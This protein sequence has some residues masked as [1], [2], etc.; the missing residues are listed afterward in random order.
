MKTT[1][2]ILIISLFGGLIKQ[3]KPT[4]SADNSQ[5]IS[6]LE[7][8]IDQNKNIVYASTFRASWTMLKEDVIKNNVIVNGAYQLGN[9]LN[10]SPYR[11]L[12]SDDWVCHAGF[13]ED[14]VLDRINSSLQSKFG[15][16]E[17]DLDQYK[18]ERDAIIC[19]SYFKKSL[20]FKVPFESLEWDFQSN[21]GS[22]RVDCFGVSKSRDDEQTEE[23]KARRQQVKIYDYRNP[24]DFI[25][26]LEGKEENKE[27]ILAKV[28]PGKTVKETLITVL[29]RMQLSA[30]EDLI[31][32]DELIIPK[33][34][35]EINHSYDELV[36]KFL[37]NPGFTEYFFTQAS[38]EI[39][40]SLD[41][42]GAHGS[43]NGEIVKIKGPT[44]TLYHFDKP[45]L[46]IMKDKDQA[47]P[48]LV[49]WI[50][51]TDYLVTTD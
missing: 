23:L 1:A 46:L 38:Q 49:M 17:T 2:L 15:I 32:L 13:V 7:E 39:N 12:N 30:P 43:A 18:D 36:G 37:A 26:R 25:V 50:A 31:F 5:I 3:D 41:E 33:I 34:N 9:M 44:S 11:P 29:V 16:M 51:N 4:K 24:D 27:I 21:G 10:K 8:K 42:S 48:D 45:F 14:G 28:Q 35:L 6:H 40:F 19:Y 47:E 22:D 20:N